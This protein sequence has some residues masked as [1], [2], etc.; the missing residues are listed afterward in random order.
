MATRPRAAA[1][2][3][4]SCGSVSKLGNPYST[5]RSASSIWPVRKSSV[6]RCASS[7]VSMPPTTDGTA[8]RSGR[9]D[10]GRLGRKNLRARG[11]RDARG[12]NTSLCGGADRRALHFAADKG[13]EGGEIVLEAA[14]EIARNL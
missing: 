8:Q 1:H 12:P 4:V 3:E 6:R 7:I 13:L 9:K 11:G 10:R 14:A 5:A 2:S